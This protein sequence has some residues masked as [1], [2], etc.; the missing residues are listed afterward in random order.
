MIATLSEA[1]R[2]KRSLPRAVLPV[3]GVR[4]DKEGDVPLHVQ[5]RNGLR[6]VIVNHFEAGDEFYTE[7]ALEREL[8]VSK[9]TIRRALD[10]LGR[11]GLLVRQRGRSSRVGATQATRSADA[12]PTTQPATLA[13]SPTPAPGIRTKLIGV[14]VPAFAPG[15]VS[16][17][18]DAIS[19]A[20]A[21]FGVAS[22]YFHIPNAEAA[23]TAFRD[24]PMSP[25]DMS[26]ILF[27]NTDIMNL[28]YFGLQGKGYRIVSID[29]APF[30]SPCAFV[31]TDSARAIDTGMGHL[32]ALGHERITLVLNEPLS[33]P[34]VLTKVN[35]FNEIVREKGLER[36]ARVHELDRS[37]LDSH[38]C[39]LPAMPEIWNHSEGRPTALFTVSDPGAW[40][41]MNWLTDNGVDVPGDVSVLGFEDAHPSRF[42][43][44]ALTTVAHPYTEL[45][46]RAVQ[47][48]C[49][50]DYS[51][52]HHEL[53]APR[54]VIRSSTGPAKPA[55]IRKI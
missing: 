11:E 28:L 3:L 34:T 40:A 13:S 30:D 19:R 50:Q 46:Q 10:D 43:R 15:Y 14:C 9:I 44:P 41:V 25:D 48:L 22:Q 37:G 24:I 17:E 35:R 55:A 29:S 4:V 32:L 36:V 7:Q 42:V 21:H 39:V 52:K 26:F 18:I 51:P 31:M 49:A 23:S 1:N 53:V 5:V 2:R 38:D 54:L 12:S 33:H 45:A 8:P 16:Q 27:C 20:C 47:V 6:T